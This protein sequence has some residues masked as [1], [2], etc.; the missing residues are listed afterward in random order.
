VGGF[1]LFLLRLNTRDGPGSSPGRF[2]AGLGYHAVILF[3]LYSVTS[4]YSL[5][6]RQKKSL[7]D[8]LTLRD[9][10]RGSSKN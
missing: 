10:E 6:K 1:V 5:L 2:F 9:E 7:R 8:F 3:F 4:Y